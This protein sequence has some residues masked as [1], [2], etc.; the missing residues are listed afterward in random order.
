M[1]FPY[2]NIVI[3]TGAG[4]SAESGIQTFRAQDGL[5]ENHKIED[6]ATPEGFQR[7]PDLVQAFYNKRRKG[8][9]SPD[10]EPN[11]AHKALGELEKRLDGKV[12]IITQNIDNLHERGGSDN[13]IHM[14]GELL[15]ARCSESN[16][17][18]E[19]KDDILTGEL[20]HCCQIPAQMRPHIVWFGEMPLRMGDIYSALEEADLFISIGTSGVVYPAA[21]FVHDAKMH[22]AHTIEIN[23]EPSAVESEFVEKRYGKASIEVPKLVSE[24]LYEEPKSL[25]A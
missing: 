13:V 25:R 6:V 5:W 11:A 1:N 18:I 21:G 24:L 3:L 10:I 22:G 7:D 2:R 17:V 16:Q 9:Q 4:I 14:H 19:H 20:C 15:K 12:T 23:L 8:L